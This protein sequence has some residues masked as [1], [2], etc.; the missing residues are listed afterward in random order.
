M[1]FEKTIRAVNAR[2]AIRGRPK[3]VPTPRTGIILAVALLAFSGDRR[4]V[5]DEEST[6]LA[7]A[8]RSRRSVSLRRLHNVHRRRR[9]LPLVAFCLI[10]RTISCMSP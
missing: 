7:A 4:R 5:K 10:T 1:P 3:I 9:V 8:A 2:P 6:G